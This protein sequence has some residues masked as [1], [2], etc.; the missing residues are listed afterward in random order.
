MPELQRQP[1]AATIDGHGIAIRAPEIAGQFLVSGTDMPANAIEGSDPYALWLAP[2]HRL[3]VGGAVPDGTFVSDVTDGMVVIELFGT[4]TDD[5][6]AMGCP[7]DLASLA[8]GRC[9]QT[10]FAGVK[11]LLYRRGDAVR[12]HVERPLAHWLL[13]WLRQAAT[14]VEPGG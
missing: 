8:P 4:R 9:A 14:S 3:V 2:G 13:D 7:L 11:V 5:I 12:L 10:L 1:I 6:L